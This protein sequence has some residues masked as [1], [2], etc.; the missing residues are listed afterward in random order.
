MTRANGSDP[1]IDQMLIIIELS[2]IRG[3]AIFFQRPN[4]IGLEGPDF[5]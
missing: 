3:S 1:K 2:L 4:N 5:T